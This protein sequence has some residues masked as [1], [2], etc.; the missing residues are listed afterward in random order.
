M[1]VTN[2]VLTRL[3]FYLAATGTLFGCAGM[4]GSPTA[5]PD[6]VE[7]VSAMEFV[8]IKGG[9]F[10]MGTPH[11]S[12]GL[13][14]PV[15]TVALKDFAAGMYEV[16]FEQY[17][18]FCI[19]TGR[20]KPSD[21]G[22]GRGDRP[23]INVSWDDAVAFT[24]WLGSETGLNVSLPSEAQWEYLARAGTTGRYW[25]GD[26]LPKNM[27]NCRECG[28]KWDNQ[29]TAPVGSFPANPWKIHD[30]MGNVAEWVLDDMH[31]NY[32]GAPTDGSAWIDGSTNRKV[33]RGGA[34]NY[35]IDSLAAATRERNRRKSQRSEIGFRVVI[36]NPPFQTPP[37]AQ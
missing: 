28:S 30:T 2:S 22:W 14:S 25:T 13:E 4:M 10:Q 15:H 8:F 34:W 32:E 18:K 20:E 35:S 16:T 5:T 7:P 12:G 24:E 33:N 36:N 31:Q 1:T 17:D 9:S 19:A 23:V 37:P 29:K 11:S 21:E 26:S 3:F 6:Y 27:A